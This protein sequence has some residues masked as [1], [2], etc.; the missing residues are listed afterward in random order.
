MRVRFL[1]SVSAK[2]SRSR[3]AHHVRTFVS[4]SIKV[5]GW[6]DINPQIVRAESNP[7]AFR[8]NGVGFLGNHCWAKV[9]NMYE[10]RT[11]E[12]E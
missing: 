8:P 10:E 12:G 4:R 9:K 3:N 11:S 7:N 1:L 6:D 2:D 5:N